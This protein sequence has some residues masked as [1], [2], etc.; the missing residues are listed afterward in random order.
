[1]SLCRSTLISPSVN[2]LLTVI[3]HLMKPHLCLSKNTCVSWFH[4]IIEVSVAF[5]CKICY[6][7]L[8][9]YGVETILSVEKCACPKYP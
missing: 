5:F 6:H 3:L 4:Y 7:S 8:E 9:R 1:M 2:L